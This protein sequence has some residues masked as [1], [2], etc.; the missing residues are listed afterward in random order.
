MEWGWHGHELKAS[1]Y[2]MMA[3]NLT[4]SM[5]M[6]LDDHSTWMNVIHQRK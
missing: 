2:N 1:S 6:L 4:T 3:Y 5:N